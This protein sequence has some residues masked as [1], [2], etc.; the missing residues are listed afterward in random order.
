MTADSRQTGEMPF[1]EHLDELRGVLQ[2]VVAACVLGGVAGWWVAPRL[3]EDLIRRTVGNVVV[4]SPLEAFNERF[5]LALLLGALLSLPFVFYRVWAFVM[6]GLMR[7]ERSILLPL[8][9]ASVLLFAAGVAAA[10][11]Y[12]VPL[13]VK[14]LQ[15]FMTPSMTAQIRVGSLLGFFYNLALACG[16]VMQMPLVT[17]GLAALGLVTPGAM[18]RHWRY[19]LVGI[20]AL[21]AVITPGDIVT[22]QILMAGPMLLLYFL[23]VAL[24]AL[25]VR[26]RAAAE[27]RAELLPGPRPPDGGSHA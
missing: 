7:R 20:F 17:M 19:A 6:P 16:L 22:A 11:F 8:S 10:Y 5:K 9:I 18:L 23:S 14:M 24:A 4:L 1:L 26:R 12:L 27:E 13:V 2:H 25:V 21:T 3:L 15:Q